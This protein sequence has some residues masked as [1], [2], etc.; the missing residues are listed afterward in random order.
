MQVTVVGVGALGSHVVQFLRNEDGSIRVVDFDRVE[1]RNVQAQ[2]HGMPSV[3]KLKVQSLAQTMQF[4]FGAK[5]V[6]VPHRLAPENA[7]EILGVAEL[8]I[9]CLDNGAT[10]RLVQQVVRARQVPCVH[11]ALAADGSFGR[12]IWDEAFVIDDEPTEAAPTCEDGAFL[13]FVGITAAY[14][15]RAAQIYLRQR[16]KVGFSISPAGVV[17]V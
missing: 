6:T 9:D 12:V 11:G 14:V 17:T 4:L 13:P 8:V 16:R 15:A 1:K 5:I 2:F 3:G 10:R 7:S